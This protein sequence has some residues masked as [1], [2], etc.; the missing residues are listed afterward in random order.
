MLIGARSRNAVTCFFFHFSLF[1]ILLKESGPLHVNDS[2]IEAELENFPMEARLLIQGAGG[3]GQ[4]LAKSILFYHLDN[5]VSLLVDSTKARA[6]V[7]DNK[8]QNSE[9]QANKPRT[10]VLPPDTRSRDH[11]PTLGASS[12]EEN[13]FY[14]NQLE[15]SQSQH[16]MRGVVRD[17]M[18]KRET[19]TPDSEYTSASDPLDNFFSAQLSQTLS[20][21]SMDDRDKSDVTLPTLTAVESKFPLATDSDYSQNLF[22]PS[23][24]GDSKSQ[25]T[26]IGNSISSGF[27]SPGLVPNFSDEIGIPLVLD[28]TKEARD[29]APPM[30]S[31]GLIHEMMGAKPLNQLS[32][33]DHPL[34][35]SHSNNSIASEDKAQQNTSDE[36]KITRKSPVKESLTG[37]SKPVNIIMQQDL[38]S[39]PLPETRQNRDLLPRSSPMAKQVELLAPGTRLTPEQATITPPRPRYAASDAPEPEFTI[40]GS[41]PPHP[42]MEDTLNV[43]S[44]VTSVDSLISMPTTSLGNSVRSW[45]STDIAAPLG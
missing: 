21:S 12:S 9:G 1:A 29:A 44:P 18:F 4:F 38:N 23:A 27:V 24:Y 3:I 35:K 2:R 30:S 43:S 39:S 37:D 40:H 31:P 26:T 36:N 19:S 8:Q 45:M 33:M 10:R 41:V 25:E 15:R 7:R 20:Q 32:L 42:D 34:L 22:M 13:Q 28:T 11:F 17:N 5:Y 16:N 6:L 14:K